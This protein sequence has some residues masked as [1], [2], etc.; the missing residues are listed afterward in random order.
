[1]RK[2][3]TSA[4]L[5]LLACAMMAQSTARTFTLSNSTDGKSTITVFLP[6][7]SL[8]TGR[9]IVACPGGGY[10]NLA[11]RHEGTDWAEYFNNQGIAYVVLKYRMPAGDRQ[12]PVSDAENAIKTVRDSAAVWHV[13]P[14]DVGIMGFSAGGHLASTIS[15]HADWNVRPNFS[16]LFYPVIS[17]DKTL[18]DRGSSERFLGM[19]QDDKSLIEQYSNERQVSRHLTPPALILTASD[20]RTVNPVTNG[21]AYYNAMRVAGNNAAMYIYPTG[22]HGFGFNKSFTYHDQMLTDLTQWLKTFKTPAQTAIRVACIG[23]SITDGDGIDMQDEFSYPAQLQADLGE[24]YSVRNFGVSARTLLNKGDFPY[25]KERAWQDALASNPNIVIVKLGTNDSK[26]GN[27][28][29]GKEFEHDLQQMVDSLKA[30]PAKPKVFIAYPI[31]AFKPSWTINDSVI[32]NGIIPVINKVAKRNKL[33]TIDLHSVITDSN[34]VQEDGIH[35][36]QEG[37]ALMA[38]VIAGAIEDSTI[39]RNM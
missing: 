19:G 17:M 6:N 24:G 13:N 36:K 16:I 15:T 28:K 34:M 31:K 7:Q 32:I 29:Y 1:M 20:D 5:S 38:K 22:G 23:N 14:Y 26:D 9:V 11:I 2:V 35:P 18:G 39:K 10:S 33:A 37:A 3:I 21:V 12:I 30:L 8:A 27:W 4:L 25:M